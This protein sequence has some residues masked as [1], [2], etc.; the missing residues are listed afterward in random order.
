MSDAIQPSENA[1]TSTTLDLSEWSTE[2]LLQELNKA[3]TNGG[4]SPFRK[5][6]AMDERRHLLR[7][8]IYA[9]G[10]RYAGVSLLNFK[11]LSTEIANEAQRE[12]FRFAKDL[13][14]RIEHGDGLF[15]YGTEGTGKDH[16]MF[17]LLIDAVVNCGYTAVWC[18][19]VEL[20]GKFRQA[21]R[22]SSEYELREEYA[23]P[24]IL[25]ISDPLPLAG[26]LT[27]WNVDVLRD[28][29]D[30]RYS[31]GLG[32]WVTVN[33][34]DMKELAGRIPAPLLSRLLENAT[35]VRFFWPSYRTGMLEQAR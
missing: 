17:S 14:Q 12:I 6:L 13:P 8:L 10:I 15:L 28:I 22:E 27:S 23:K 7:R 18:D 34:F 11:W 2:D 4:L 24:H 3:L 35:V 20:F 33:A 16:I 21:I 29:V 9:R 31:R 26:E 5:K 25:A 32:T 1:A 19:G 30:R